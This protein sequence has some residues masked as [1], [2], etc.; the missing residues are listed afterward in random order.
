MIRRKI[1]SIRKKEKQINFKSKVKFI[2]CSKKEN[3]M[4]NNENI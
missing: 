3:V 1:K 2:S 4:I